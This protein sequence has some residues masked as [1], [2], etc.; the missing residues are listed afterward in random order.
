MNERPPLGMSS[1]RSVKEV[2]ILSTECL[3]TS[4]DFHALSTAEATLTIAYSSAKYSPRD[5]QRTPSYTTPFHGPIV[6]AF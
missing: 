5:S 6:S 2:S 4:F 1:Y 3:M